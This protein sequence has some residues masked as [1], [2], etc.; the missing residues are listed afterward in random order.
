MNTKQ[1]AS[2]RFGR[3]LVL[4]RTSQKK[5][6][7]YLWRCL[8]DCGKE[9]LATTYSLTSSATR[10]CGCLQQDSRKQDLTGRVFGRLTVIAAAATTRHHNQLWNC[11][12][13][14][15]NTIEIM[16]SSLTGG[17]TR[18]CGCLHTDA[19]RIQQTDMVTKTF[20]DG[21]HPGLIAS[22]KLHSNNTSG[23]RGV[24]WHRRMGKWQ[25][26]IMYQGKAISLGTFINFEDAVKARRAAEEEYF[27]KYIVRYG[28]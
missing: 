6:S 12:C 22:D 21:T 19:A 5:G 16:T 9:K 27:A 4:D 11:R 10:S 7:C 24:S 20:R 2:Q 1:L 3:L 13:D 25:A 28:K 17:A 18:S 26:R 23:V 15:G 8:C 14:C